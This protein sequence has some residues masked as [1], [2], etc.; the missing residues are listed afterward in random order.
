MPNVNLD[1]EKNVKNSLFFFLLRDSLPI[2]TADSGFEY[3]IDEFNRDKKELIAY[4]IDRIEKNE[5]DLEDVFCQKEQMDN[6]IFETLVLRLLNEKFKNI[7]KKDYQRYF[8]NTIPKNLRKE[9]LERDGNK[10]Q[11][12]GIDL[13]SLEKMGF[14]AHVDHIKPRRSGGKHNPENLVACCW[15]C[16]LGKKDFDLFEYEDDE[17]SD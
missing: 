10:C 9:I 16:N 5:S 2:G 15:K 17:S 11:Y 7:L 3:T 14:P 12:C 6:D 1:K 13:N 4:I 8:K